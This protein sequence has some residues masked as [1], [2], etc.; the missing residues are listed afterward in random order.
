MTTNDFPV[1]QMYI[2][3]CCIFKYL[4][5][6]YIK[7]LIDEH[8]GGVNLRG[9]KAYFPNFTLGQSYSTSAL[10]TVWVKHGR[11]LCITGHLEAP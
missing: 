5:K 9:P 3:K 6:K 2:G 11:L 1:I 7:C 8:Q 10:L 4:Y